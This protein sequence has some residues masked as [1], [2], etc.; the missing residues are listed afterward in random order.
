L[1]TADVDNDGFTD[2]LVGTP[3]EDVGSQTDSGIAQIIWGASGGLGKGKASSEL[4]QSS[5]GRTVTAGD[6]LGYAVDTVKEL[7]ADSPMVAVGVPGGNVSG[8]NDAGWAGFLSAGLSDPRAIDQNSPSLPGSAEAGDRFG[9]AITLGLLA[10]TSNRV[11][12]AV[13]IPS[14]DVG[15]I[16]N[17]GAISTIDDLY[18]GAVAGQIFDQET[19]GVPGAAENGDSFGQVVDSVRAGSTTHLAV[20]VASEDAGSVADT[21]SVQLF[22]S[23]GVTVTPGVGLSQD[24]TNVTDTSEAGDRFGRQLVLAPPG[25]GDTKTR[26]AV[27]SPY[28]DGPATDTGQVQIFPLDDLGA[29][30][31]YDQ[32]STGMVGSAAANDQFGG[33]L[34]FVAGVGERAFLVGVPNDVEF[35]GGM[36]NVIPLTGG[37]MRSWRPGAGTSLSLGRTGSA[38]PRAGRY[39]SSARSPFQSLKVLITSRH[40]LGLRL[41]QVRR[42][43]TWCRAVT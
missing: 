16:S 7:G 36:V 12:A 34:G 15:S 26:L 30:V 38:P 24:T 40:V 32:D 23:N 20:G 3:Y 5:F 25:L 43:E 21:G 8:Q 6:Q 39:S 11:D 28:E 41:V 31:T 4:T 37:S 22:S 14:E 18:T 19:T 35:S 27:S 10:G 17:A 9:E 2:L 13:G 42:C 29:E 33:G 1:A